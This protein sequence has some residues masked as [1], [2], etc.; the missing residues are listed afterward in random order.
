MAGLS[1]KLTLPHVERGDFIIPFGWQIDTTRMILAIVSL[2]LVAPPALLRIVQRDRVAGGVAHRAS[3]TSEDVRHFEL[4][5]SFQ[6]DQLIVLHL[7]EGPNG[8]RMTFAVIVLEEG[9]HAPFVFLIR[10]K[11]HCGDLY[12]ILYVA[13]R[14][15]ASSRHSLGTLT[16]I[17]IA[18]AE[19]ICDVFATSPRFYSH[20]INDLDI[21][22]KS[23]PA[24][25]CVG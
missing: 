16:L 3:L 14:L 23:P 9:C 20:F 22:I 8:A 6:H 21:F 10:S 24:I 1:V 5:R 12:I 4:T 13:D 19:P 7:V 25:S 18:C 15:I 2:S 11:L 17:L